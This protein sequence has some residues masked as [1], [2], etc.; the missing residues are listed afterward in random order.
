MMRKIFRFIFY[1]V[2]CTLGT[3]ILILLI[4]N[5]MED[6]DSY[7]WSGEYGYGEFEIKAEEPAASSRLAGD[8]ST[9]APPP[10]MSGKNEKK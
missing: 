7:D 3:L 4:R 5:H 10:D 2:I 8:S 6:S 9:V 1:T